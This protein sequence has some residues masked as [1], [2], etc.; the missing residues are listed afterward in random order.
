MCL[1]D[2][3]FA[4]PAAPACLQ[5]PQNWQTMQQISYQN[6]GT[7]KRLQE[8]SKAPLIGRREQLVSR[9]GDTTAIG[10]LMSAC[11]LRLEQAMQPMAQVLKPM[12]A[13]QDCKLSWGR[14]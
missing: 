14:T 2:L 12:V 8:Y 7:A 1:H 11:R 9:H 6:P 10:A 4:P 5:P 13:S 3:L